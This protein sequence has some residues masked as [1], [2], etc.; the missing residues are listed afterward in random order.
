MDIKKEIVK[1][2]LWIAAVWL[3]CFVTK[4][5]ILFVVCAV[6]F[7]AALSRKVALAWSCWTILTMA[8]TLNSIIVPKSGMVLGLLLRVGP[9]LIA[10]AT[11]LVARSGVR[12]KLPI[13]SLSL[14]LIAQVVS[15]MNGLVPQV[16]FLKL[17]QFF[18]FFFGLWLGTGTLAGNFEELKRMR[19]FFLS[20]ILVLVIGS[21]ISYP[22]PAISYS[23]SLRA[24]TL[25]KN[26]S[27][28]YI[29]NEL[30]QAGGVMLF[31]GITD[32]SQTLAPFLS[33]MLIYVAS[34]MIFIERRVT[35]LQTAMIFVMFIML[36]MTR[37]RTGLF[38]VAASGFI[39]VSYIFKKI[40]IP[41]DLK[42]RLHSAMVLGGIVMLIA[43]AVMEVRSQTFSKWLRKTNDIESDSRSMSEA[44]TETRQGLIDQ[45]MYEFRKN[46][47]TGIGFQVSEQVKDLYS[48]NSGLLLSAPIE[49]GLLP[50]MVL[51]EGGIV[52][53]LLFYIFVFSFISGCIKKKYFVSLLLFIAFFGTNIGEASFFSPGGPGGVMWAFFALGGFSMDQMIKIS[54][55]A[56]IAYNGYNF[57]H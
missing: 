52:G 10:F 35:T 25:G 23:T 7:F 44:I 3:L 40:Y 5:N 27:V 50:L 43:L 18:A 31:S 19:V 24:F 28:E 11:I 20:L 1:Q 29:Y 6:G 32:H 13:G 34:D 36:F 45:C 17:F 53:A 37:S 49:K 15:S 4:S 55:R 38:A 54:N 48:Q 8:V 12:D 16:S 21:I 33:I 42:R 14:Y 41:N 39:M 51:G 30:V 57:S 46:R 2:S 56:Q 9:L 22:F 26:E 47:I